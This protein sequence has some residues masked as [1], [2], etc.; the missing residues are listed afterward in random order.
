MEEKKKPHLSGV[1]FPGQTVIFHGQR[2]L[3][4]FQNKDGTFGHETSRFPFNS[5]INPFLLV[6]PLLDIFLLV[7]F[8]ISQQRAAQENF[9]VLY[10]FD[11]ASLG[12]AVEGIL[13]F[14]GFMIPLVVV[15]FVFRPYFQQVCPW[16]GLEHKLI[17]AA[18]EKDIGNAENHSRI[19]EQCGCTYMLTIMI[20][21]ITYTLVAYGIFGMNVPVGL[22]TTILINMYFESRYFHKE[23]TWGLRLGIWLQEHYLTSEPSE[24]LISYGKKAMAE[25]MGGK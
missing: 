15:W 5:P 22:P 18:E 23:N 8:L 10:T 9:V 4:I 2:I 13:S 25:F 3:K 16:H 24:D 1:S 12:M 17:L 11:N 20:T 19:A 7:L 14:I 6:Y 21:V